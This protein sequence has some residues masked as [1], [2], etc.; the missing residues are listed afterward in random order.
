MIDI[1]AC[2]LVGWLVTAAA[3]SMAGERRFNDRSAVGSTLTV[4]GSI[5]LIALLV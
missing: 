1:L 3:A 2:L 5:A 4:A